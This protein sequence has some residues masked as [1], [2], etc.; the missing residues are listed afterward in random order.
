MIERES[1]SMK[2]L[3]IVAHSAEG[4]SLCFLTACRE[5]QKVMGPHMHPEIVVSA[6]PMG[7]SMP[8]LGDERP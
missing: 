6:I 5:G 7:L 1:P 2:R 3:G 4:A 8:P